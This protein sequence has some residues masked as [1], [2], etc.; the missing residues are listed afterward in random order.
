[1]CI[2]DSIKADK[3]WVPFEFGVRPSQ[4]VDVDPDG[5]V[6]PLCDTAPEPNPKTEVDEFA[7]LDTTFNQ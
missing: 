3:N 1:M 5:G 6:V 4:I 2:R 7:E